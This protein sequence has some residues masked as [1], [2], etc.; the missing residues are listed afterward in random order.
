MFRQFQQ[1]VGSCVAQKDQL[2]PPFDLAEHIAQ[3]L[4]RFDRLHQHQSIETKE[5][6]KQVQAWQRER[7]QN[8]HA[9]LLNDRV[10]RDAICFLFSEVYGGVDLSPVARDIRRAYPL[11]MKIF[12]ENV[13]RTASLALE[14]NALTAELDEQVASILFSHSLSVRKEIDLVSYLQAFQMA[15]SLDIRLHQLKLAES[16]LAS[17]DCYINS[18]MIFGAFKLARGPAKAA[19]LVHLYQFMEKG[20]T[21]LRPLESPSRFMADIFVKEKVYMQSIFA[22]QLSPYENIA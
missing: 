3:S 20:F 19:G 13:M 11:A 9:P 21:V 18:R 16:L 2:D 7:F 14:L 17:I 1:D 10:K 4:N 5:K 22:G 6:V 8:S 12:S 15:S